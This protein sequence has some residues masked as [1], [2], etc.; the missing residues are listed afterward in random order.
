MFETR[1]V[2]NRLKTLVIGYGNPSRFDDG[3]GPL[4][5]ERL[6]VENI[7]GV[8][9]DSSIMINVEHAE[10]ISKYDVVIFVDADV[11]GA[12]PFYF[13]RIEPRKLNNFHSHRIHPEVL[14]GM[15]HRLFQANT[16]GYVMGIRGYLFNGFGEDISEEAQNNLNQAFVFLA[17]QLRSEEFSNITK[18]NSYP[19]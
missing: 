19:G 1:A 4:L 9:L 2:K 7:P 14:L 16:I 6:G 17:D 5:I 12:E 13:K 10:Q 18:S 15:A 3:L 8:T 11:S